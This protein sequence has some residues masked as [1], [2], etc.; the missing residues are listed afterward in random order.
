[1]RF[2]SLSSVLLAAAS[3]ASASTFPRPLNKRDATQSCTDLTISA[4]DGDRK[5]A[6]V[7]D[8]SGSMASTDPSDLRLSAGRALN[9]FLIS[10]SEATGGKKADLVTIIQFNGSAYVDFPLGDPGDAGVYAAFNMIGADGDTCIACGV[11]T[12]IEQLTSANSGA[13]DSR[14]AI[15]VF[16]DGEDFDTDTLVTNIKKATSLGIRVSFGFLDATASAQ[17]EEILLAVRDSKGV[18]A[19]I[20]LAAGSQNFI[21][22]VLLNGLCYN[23]NP[24]GYN[25]QLLAGLAETQFISGSNAVTLKYAA[26]QGENVNFTLYSLTGDDLSASAQMNGQT[27]QTAASSSYYPFI[28]VTAPSSGELDLVVTASNSPK[29]GL[30]QVITN[31]NQP[32]KNCTVGVG[33]GGSSGL[34]SGAKAGLG[35]GITALLLGLAGGG[36]YLY[37]HFYGG[38]SSMGPPAT[39]GA[40]PGTDGNLGGYQPGA[41]KLGP[42]AHVYPTGSP[43]GSPPPQSPMAGGQGYTPMYT[44]GGVE[45]NL[46]AGQAV[47]TAPGLS[48]GGPP[49]AMSPMGGPPMSPPGSPPPMGMP[50]AG[51][52]PPVSPWSP[53]AAFVPPMIPPNALN[54]NNPAQ[55]DPNNR[56][57]DTIAHN[58]PPPQYLGDSKGGAQ[59]TL[60]PYNTYQQNL[61]PDVGYDNLAPVSP[62]STMGPGSEIQGYQQNLTQGN[63]FAPMN[64]PPQ[65]NMMPGQYGYQ[66]PLGA[67][68]SDG[69]QQ[70]L[71]NPNT[72]YQPMSPSSPGSST[73]SPYSHPGTPFQAAPPQSTA[74]TTPFGGD[75]TNP[76]SAPHTDM[77]NTGYAGGGGDGGGA[78]GAGGGGGGEGCDPTGG[79][80]YTQQN[81]GFTMPGAPVRQGG[82]E[83]KHH[84]HEWLAPDTACEHPQCPLNLPEHLCEPEMRNTCPCTCRDEDCGYMRRG[85]GVGA[86]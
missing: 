16:T 51:S 37:R 45:G 67:P 6:I 54:P 84:H 1:M 62:T 34:S 30:F 41:E 25:E 72:A 35:V 11:E 74:P 47:G 21:N 19:T 22:Y 55:R 65:Q 17:P 77:G 27:L 7:I 39:N 76:Y 75:A 20:T 60:G 64:S 38:A 26:A 5:V 42:D 81:P 86:M 48:G 33:G 15:V 50:P 57:Q 24:Q 59:Q 9:N 13:T 36:F 68:G 4:N 82:K 79:S 56:G 61:G 85:L 52:P 29:D 14:S 70:Y 71:G 3:V 12:A 53:P 32:I 69:T 66:Q 58:Q 83:K 40:A 28:N 46:T 73:L 78:G 80:G 63:Q 23:D 8:S 43:L 18:Y 49:P 2:A 44:P 10:N 31:S